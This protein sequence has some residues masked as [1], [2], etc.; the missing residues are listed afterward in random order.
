[1]DTIAEHVHATAVRHQLDPEL[2][3]A[4]VLV[5]SSGRPDA[6]RYEPHF[7]AMYI[8]GNASAKATRFGPLAACS[9]GLLQIMLETACELG[10]GGQP[11]D[12]FDPAI[13][14]EWGAQHFAALLAWAAGDYRRALAAYN[15]GKAGN[16]V[17]P[18]RNDLYARRVFAM[19]G[20]PLTT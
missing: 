10:F 3:A 16:E 13:G 4:Q 14:L 7:Y 11:C 20:H 19:R 17:Q 12:L 5:E 1:M 18:F 9:F 2:L 6:F 8:R 15:G